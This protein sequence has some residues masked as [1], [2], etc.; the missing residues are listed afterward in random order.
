MRPISTILAFALFCIGTGYLWVEG[1]LSTAA[2]LGATRIPASAKL[3]TTY[4]P[5]LVVGVLVWLAWAL[6]AGRESN[7]QPRGKAPIVI[8]VSLCVSLF[9][10][11]I[12]TGLTVFVFHDGP[13]SG[14]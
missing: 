8:G 12:S 10:F 7:T 14:G 4:A 13:L 11:Y 9:L 6:Y 3:A 1:C 5:L 2:K